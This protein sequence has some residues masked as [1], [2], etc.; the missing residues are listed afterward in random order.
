MS[1]RQIVQDFRV[2]PRGSRNVRVDRHEFSDPIRALRRRSASRPAWDV[3]RPEQGRPDHPGAALLP[4]DVRLT[5]VDD[6]FDNRVRKWAREVGVLDRI[7]LTGTS[8]R[9]AS[10][11]GT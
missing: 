9:P 2:S 6:D 4:S 8:L 1:A 7:T 11:D 5:L 10:C 3:E